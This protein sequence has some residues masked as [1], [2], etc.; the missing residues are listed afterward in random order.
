MELPIT[1]NYEDNFNILGKI[2][3]GGFA[4]VYK[5]KN[6]LDDN[7]YALKKIKVQLEGK[8]ESEEIGRVIKEAKTLSCL[9]HPNIVRYYGSWTHTEISRKSS[10]INKVQDSFFKSNNSESSSMLDNSQQLS[11]PMFFNASNDNSINCTNK[12]DSK[13][14]PSY[15]SMKKNNAKNKDNDNYPKSRKNK[16]KGKN[17]MCEE[18]SSLTFMTMGTEENNNE[19]EDELSHLMK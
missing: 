10:K 12:N 14:N 8:N 19:F 6:I 4:S 2:G 11:Q 17:L 16:Q 18:E 13:Q 3:R 1:K 5:V 15:S 9:S 7:E